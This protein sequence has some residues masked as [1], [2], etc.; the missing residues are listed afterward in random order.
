MKKGSEKISDQQMVIIRGKDNGKQTPGNLI[1]IQGGELAFECL[2]MEPSD[3]GNEQ[4]ISCIPRGTYFIEKHNS[5]KYDYCFKVLDVLGRANILISLFDPTVTMKG[6]I[7]V[8]KTSK[9]FAVDEISRTNFSP[10]IVRKL[11]QT[12]KG[13][14][15]FLL[16]II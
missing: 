6:D 15:K 1:L 12:V 4:H 13:K 7:K 8:G 14:D 11:Y 9:D 16:R 2:T 3:K 10:T 5:I